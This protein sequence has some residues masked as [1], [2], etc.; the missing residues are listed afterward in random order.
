MGVGELQLIVND[1]LS[2][3][4]GRLVRLLLIIFY[5]ILHRDELRI[6]RTVQFLHYIQKWCV[7]VY[8]VKY[9]DD[10][11]FLSVCMSACQRTYFTSHTSKFYYIVVLVACIVITRFSPDSM[12]YFIYFQFCGWRHVF[13]TPPVPFAGMHSSERLTAGLVIHF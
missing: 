5:F 9:C 13:I 8:I 1:L 2:Q 7:V 4:E 6:Q 3:I 11:V 10:R 12:Q